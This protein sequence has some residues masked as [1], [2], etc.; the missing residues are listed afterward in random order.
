[1]KVV[2]K[3]NMNHKKA[4]LIHSLVV[5]RKALSVA[6]RGNE[7]LI[8]IFFECWVFRSFSVTFATF[9]V[10]VQ[11]IIPYF[12]LLWAFVH[13]VIETVLHTLRRQF[14]RAT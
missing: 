13:K 3:N 1:M 10:F 4:N 14:S 6:D 2:N 8:S 9:D 11:S 7:N 5:H 12:L